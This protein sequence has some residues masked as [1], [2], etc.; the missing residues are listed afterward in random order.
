[1]R[2]SKGKRILDLVL[3]PSLMKHTWPQALA[4]TWWKFE[5]SPRKASMTNG[6]RKCHIRFNCLR[7]STPLNTEPRAILACQGLT[8]SW[9]VPC[10]VRMMGVFPYAK[11]DQDN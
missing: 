2:Y 6:Y 8:Q 3:S 1:M 10:V 4:D 7:R 5:N 9:N 11:T